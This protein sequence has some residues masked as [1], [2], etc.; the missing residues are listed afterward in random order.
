MT[1]RWMG[2]HRIWHGSGQVFD[3]VDLFLPDVQ[4]PTQVSLCLLQTVRISI[5]TQK[6]RTGRQL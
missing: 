6:R 3:T 4:F 2:F 1:T 5:G